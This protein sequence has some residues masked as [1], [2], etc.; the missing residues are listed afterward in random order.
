MSL[1]KKIIQEINTIFSEA[2]F[3]M[4]LIEFQCWRPVTHDS[5]YV[6]F[7]PIDNAARLIE[8]HPV[9][10]MIYFKFVGKE[11]EYRIRYFNESNQLDLDQIQLMYANYSPDENIKEIEKSME[12]VMGLIA[13]SVIPGAIRKLIL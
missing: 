7:E 4:T 11:Y 12:T 10:V 3:P 2:K 6:N 9:H 5:S 1:E 8:C 13:A